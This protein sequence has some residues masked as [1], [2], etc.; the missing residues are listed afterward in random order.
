[1]KQYQWH[2]WQSRA[3]FARLSRDHDR[4][5]LAGTMPPTHVI[6]KH[7]AADRGGDLIN[8]AI[9]ARRKPTR[10]SSPSRHEDVKK[11]DMNVERT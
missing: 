5:F 3:L 11:G 8:A 6:M 1:M 7:H 4:L 2:A 9:P 10:A